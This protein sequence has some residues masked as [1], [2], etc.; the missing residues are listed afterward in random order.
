MAGPLIV[1][2]GMQKVLAN[3]KRANAQMASG[4][5]VGARKGGHFLERESKKIVPR[6]TGNLVNT[7]FVRNMGGQ[8]WDVDIH[9]GYTADYAVYVHEDLTKKHGSAY[10]AA[11]AGKDQKLRGPDQQAKFLEAPAKEF[12]TEIIRII[13]KEAGL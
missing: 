13:H 2:K 8:G 7:A 3:M 9:I 12:R 11:Y 5:A 6:D 10:N 4:F 1:V